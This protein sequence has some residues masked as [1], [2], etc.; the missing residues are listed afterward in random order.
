MSGFPWF[1]HP[2]DAVREQEVRYRLVKA[3]LAG[4]INGDQMLEVATVANA[5][6]CESIHAAGAP[7]I[8]CNPTVAD[9]GFKTGPDYGAA[10]IAAAREAVGC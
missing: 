4:G 1:R 7:C 10:R 3:A 5:I 9:L 8:R 2:K 6:P